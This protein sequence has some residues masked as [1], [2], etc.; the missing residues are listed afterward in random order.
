MAGNARTTYS[1]LGSWTGTLVRALDAHGVDGAAL[2]RDAGIDPTALRDA[3]ARVPREAL[4]RLW[5]LAVAATGD[6]C[7]GLTAAGFAVPTSF[8]AL[9]YA[10]LASATLHEALER[11]VR[12]RRLI[13]D[14]VRLELRPDG[15]CDRF[16]IDVSASPGAVP[17][18]AVDAFAATIVRQ[19]RLLRAD[20]D[21]SPAAVSL[22]RPEP[23]NPAPFHRLFRAP[24]AF[25]QPSNWLAFRRADLQAPLPA[26]NAELAR[27]NEEAVVRYLARLDN[28]A[29]TSR[30]QQALLEMLPSGAPSKQAVARRLAMSA[31][32][33][34]RHL[35]GEGTSFKALLNQSR[36]ELAC[37]Y[38][39]QGGVAITEIAFVLGFADA[40]AF[41]RAFKR[42]TGVSP[43]EYGSRRS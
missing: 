23:E 20:R 19:A 21:F 5:Q 31:R 39:D 1:T 4:T 6:P 17:A 24:I 32:N 25:A 38:I 13:G 36:A 35:A 37:H 3:A 8:H 34:Q 27:Q 41:S 33:L 12:Y 14:V 26:A 18:E 29:V 10:V 30:V 11:I 22:Q 16:V 40:S 9:G 2:A 7:F 15:D 42:W 43:S 28:P